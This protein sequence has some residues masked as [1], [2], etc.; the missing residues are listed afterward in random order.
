M[1]NRNYVNLLILSN[2]LYEAGRATR[3]F[4]MSKDGVYFVI[5]TSVVM[6]WKT[7]V[8]PWMRWVVSFD[9]RWGLDFHGQANST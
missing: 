4:Y 5:G 9:R 1:I 8:Y 2:L 6:T 7:K 3:W